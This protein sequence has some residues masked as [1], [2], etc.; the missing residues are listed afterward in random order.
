MADTIF[1]CEHDSTA[2]SGGEYKTAFITIVYNSVA[3]VRLV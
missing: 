1:F 3:N 2:V